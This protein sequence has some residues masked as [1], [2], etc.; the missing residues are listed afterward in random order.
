MLPVICQL[1]VGDALAIQHYFGNSH[2]LIGT[3]VRIDKRTLGCY[4]QCITVCNAAKDNSVIA[5]GY[6]GGSV[7]NL[8]LCLD[9]ADSNL[10]L[11]D[12]CYDRLGLRI[13]M[14]GIAMHLVI[15]RI[16]TSSRRGGDLSGELLTVKTVLHGTACGLTGIHQCLRATC[17]GQDKRR[18]SGRYSCDGLCYLKRLAGSALVVTLAGNGSGSGSHIDIVSIAHAE[19]RTT[20]ELYTVQC[21]VHLGGNTLTSIDSRWNVG[22]RSILNTLRRDGCR[23][24]CL[25]PALSQLIVGDA[26]ATKRQFGNSHFLIG[27]NIS[28][29]KSALGCYC[30]CIT[31]CN[32]AKDNSVIAQGYG[33]GSVINLVLCLDIADSNLLLTDDCYDRLGL[34][35]LMVGI[36]MHLVI[37]RIGTSSRR[38]GDLSGELLTVKTVLHGTACGLTGI[39]QCLRATCIGQDKRRRSGRYSCDGLCYLKRLA[40]SALVVTLAGNGSGS[41]SH[42]DIVSIAHAEVRTTDELYTV[43]CYVHLG[44]NTLTSIDSRWNV[45]YRSILNTLRRDGCRSSCLL[46]A[47]SQLIVGDACATKRQFG[48]SHFLVGAYVRVSKRSFG[49][50]C[51]CIAI[52]NTAIDYLVID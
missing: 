9:I 37:D 21:Y 17:I 29:S 13:L 36:A 47:L 43:Q 30:Q 19:V 2:F 49:C 3:H 25:L 20:D 15:D 16:G 28:I 42:I 33:G 10:L 52:H 8:V 24:S 38:G 34:R 50:Y 35:I 40:G 41:G 26:C 51:Q 31:V 46:P 48:N 5:Q 39:H 22:Y 1:V 4:C 44:G 7:I 6:G 23:S 27:T 12:D 32:A 18:R 45:G 11:T 14:V